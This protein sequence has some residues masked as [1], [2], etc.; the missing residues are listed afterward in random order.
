M[1][2]IPGYK[3]LGLF[4]MTSSSLLFQ[5]LREADQLP[6]IV[7]TPRTEHLG[8]RERTRYQREHDILR[9]LQ[10]TPG[11]LASRGHELLQER[12]VLLLEDVGG[13]ALADQLGQPFELSRFLS[14]AISLAETLAEM[15]RRGVIHKDVKP[16]NI[17]L[18]AQ[19]QVWLIDFGLAS[20]QQVEHVE[21]ANTTFVEGTL[22][23]MSPEQSGRIN[24]AVDYRTD[25]YSLGVTLY[26]M[27]TG[28]LPFRGKDPLEWLHAHISQPP[29]PPQRWVPSLPPMVS[30]VVLKLLAKEAEARYQ[31]A[32]GLKADLERCQEA[33]RQGVVEDF[34]LGQRDF[35]ARFQLPQHLYGR[36]VE[37]EALLGA[38]ERVAR[39]GRPEWVLVRGYSGIGKSSIVHELHKP[40]LERRGFFLSG[41][42][43][44][45]QREVPYATLAQAMRSLVQQVLAGR[46]AEVEAWRQRLLEA[47]EGNGQVLVNLVPQLE[48]VVGKQP[49]ASELPPAETQNRFHR[50]FLRFLGVFATAERP[51]VLFLDDLQWADFA[52][53]KLLQYLTTHPGTPPLLLIG[54]YRDNEVNASHSLALVLEETRKA[55]ARL[56]DLHL[57]PLAPEQTRQLVADAL[58]G[59]AMELVEPLSELLQTKT[60]GNPFFLLQLFQTLH[61]DGLV[62]RGPRGGW[63]WDAEAV[64][65]RGYSDN[66]VDFMASRLRKLPEESVQLLRLAACVGNTFALDVLGLLSH[67]DGA[68]V[69]RGLEPAL[70]EG[71]VVQSSS[72]HY[73]FLHDRIQQAAYAFSEEEER[74]ATH[75]RIG[76]LL[77]TRLSPEELHERLFDVVG[78]L[79]AGVEL[80]QDVEERSRL[81]RL[82]A[83]AGQRAQASTA[84]R[85]AVGYFTMALSLL[86]ENLW[87][88]APGLAFKLRLGQ[89]SSELMSGNGPEA[90]RIVDALLPRAPSRQE[91]AA[92]Y[93]LKSI[94][95]V[96]AH[97]P[98]A[99]AL[100]LLE[101]LEHF[102][103][104]FSAKP[105]WE[106]VE[107]A[108][109]ELETLL[110][111][112][113][114]ESLIDLPPMTDP[115]L[116]ALMGLL[117]ALFAPAFFTSET[118]LAV[119][120]CRMIV[121]TIRH[122]STPE[123]ASAYVWYGFVTSCIFRNYHRGEAFGRLACE[124][125]ERND[126]TA[127][128]ARV[129]FTMG[130]LTLWVQPLTSARELYR[131]AFHHGLLSGDIQIAG[132]SSIFITW[133]YLAMGSE[134]AEV[135][136]EAVTRGEF[137]RKAGFRDA[138]NIIRFILCLVQQMRG[139]TPSFNSLSMEG[140]SEADLE[141]LLSG[142]MAPLRCSYFV[143]K[144]RSRFMCGAFEEAREA[145]DKAR[146]MRWAV[147]GRIQLLDYHH[148]RALALAAC[149]HDAPKERQ[150]QD[151]KEIQE[152]HQQ[153]AEWAANV[154]ETFRA[155]EKLVAAELERLQGR[156]EAAV[157][158][159]EEAIQVSRQY[160]LIDNV[161]LASELAARFWQEHEVSFIALAY[162]RQA[163]EAYIQWGAQGK[164]RHLDEAWPDLTRL[165]LTGQGTTS[166]D[167]G[168]RLLDALS[169]V[170]AQ[171][172]ISSEMNLEKL[173]ATLIRVA[174]ESAGAQR[175]A[176][177]LLEGDALRVAA[178]VD[179]SVEA[180]GKE[181]PL[182][183]EAQDL[184]WTVLSYV[185]RTGEHV[186]IEDISRPHDFS[187]DV[188]MSPGRVGSLLCLPLERKGAFYGLMYLENALTTEAFNPTR[189]PLLQ[190][191]ASQ[192]VISMDNARLYA[193]VRQAEAALRQANEELESR[194]EERTRELRE[195]QSRLVETA[196]MVGKTEV[197]SS[198]L[199]DVGNALTS[200]VVDT[201]ELRHTVATSRTGRVEQV[202]KL[203]ENHRDNLADF[204]T[205]DP[206]GRQLFTYLS[207]LAGE[208]A[209]EREALR[210]G[211]EDMTRNVDRVRSIIQMQQA[212][213]KATLLVEECDLAEVL[214]DALRLQAGALQHAGVKVLKELSPLPRMRVDRHRLLQILLNLLANARQAMDT[215]EPGQRQVRLR[216]Y[217]E[218]GWIH[219]QVVD[220]GKGIAPEVREQLFTQG[221]TTRKEGHGI[222]L[223]SSA[224]AAKLMGARLTLESAGQGLGATATLKLPIA[225]RETKP[226]QALLG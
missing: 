135:A 26:Q 84:H 88:T 207:G 65:A 195:A 13:K 108:R 130:H 122:G 87:E 29:A 138:S 60:G 116:K 185:R 58:H 143:I 215:V 168:S 66:V 181:A 74:K 204:L 123:S 171:Q 127:Y 71:M 178:L 17:L 221:F 119:H 53:L 125:V 150:A 209:Q 1:M 63:R 154:P 77:W 80:I 131:K 102:G 47:F 115:E 14:I 172:A 72:Q 93:R 111:D 99:A 175:G 69:E 28:Q 140:V 197:A 223:H 32:E 186:L 112:R 82:N 180:E 134:L 120:L 45:L 142:G 159:Y 211:M 121:L 198:V 8:P 191:L 38:F 11:V 43:N 166:Y 220:N 12:P 206:R 147:T 106:D 199:H 222:G 18:S 148:Y 22:A 16:A 132:Y 219:Y 202:V 210:Q 139:L 85:T 95:L 101:G 162:A 124:F 213:A 226:A 145:A 75:L 128:R 165:A 30:A 170:K 94:I 55:G 155:A 70:Q 35:P 34:P 81:G 83:E 161:A 173:V 203:L 163:R 192:A 59:A 50:L 190:H 157:Y 20:L 118:L 141:A 193:E 133:I 37:R 224:L 6:V 218:E 92:A 68:E 174:M 64:R 56:V 212:Y 188:F 152:H 4:Q 89:A 9:R 24:R 179:F 214:E 137:A 3:L 153:L 76:R 19:G 15:H 52:S 33:L 103:E 86:P 39:E 41:K 189:I 156:L 184:P 169:V 57:G 201:D 23:Y 144:T 117:G 149:Y 78:Q 208:L 114:I 105:S 31:S 91:L 25:F 44:P 177:L 10:G 136:Q 2:E 129:L 205:Q 61:Q 49:P 107:V 40:V 196:R 7:K 200:L 5:A 42:F 67:Q 79:N 167:T 187:A 100:C 96:T 90:R 113:P 217:V 164:V 62:E 146:Q 176:L 216:L 27:L 183:T 98:D 109:K 151:L 104:R 54:A 97:Q 225:E 194:V 21:E 110:G 46:D 36:E 73:R 51:L 182:D 158:A 48:K 126:N 160:G